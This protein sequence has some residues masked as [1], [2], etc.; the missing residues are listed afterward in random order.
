MW[1]SVCTLCGGAPAL[2]LI[3][4]NALTFQRYLEAKIKRR[5]ARRAVDDTGDDGP[6]KG[7]FKGKGKK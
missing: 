6:D 7:A 5:A 4:I 3:H 1:H 2:A